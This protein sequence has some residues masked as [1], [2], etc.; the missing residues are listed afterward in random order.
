MF[1]WSCA[2]AEIILKL[3]N[4]L[5]PILWSML[6][7]PFLL[8][9]TNDLLFFPRSEKANEV[10]NSLCAQTQFHYIFTKGAAIILQKCCAQGL[11]NIIAGNTHHICHRKSPHC[12]IFEKKRR[13]SWNLFMTKVETCRITWIKNL[14]S[15]GLCHQ[16]CETEHLQKLLG[17]KGM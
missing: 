7:H 15:P 9:L 16:I 10:M 5:S 17:A 11:G 6:S 13:S 1:P 4:Q 14:G 2:K 12:T 8:P 3:T